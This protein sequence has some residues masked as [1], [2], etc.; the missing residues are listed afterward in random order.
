MVLTATPVEEDIRKR[1]QLTK[2]KKENHGT[3]ASTG[4]LRA[5]GADGLNLV[6]HGEHG[7]QKP[8]FAKANAI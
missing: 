3:E 1:K 7:E 8:M 2:A 5:E 4:P 6:W